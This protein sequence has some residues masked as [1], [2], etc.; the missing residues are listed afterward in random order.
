M[1][2]DLEP[3]D[4]RPL[5]TTIVAEVIAQLAAADATLGTDRIGFPEAEAASLLGIPRHVLRDRRLA[6]EISAK[7]CGKRYLY[8]RHE[9][10][11]YLAGGDR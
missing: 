5:V 6:G 9:L 10:L 8:S 7:L 2:L 1:K 3:D 4:L 11:S